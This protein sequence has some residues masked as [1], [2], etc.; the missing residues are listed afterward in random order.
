MVV[1]GYALAAILWIMLSDRLLFSV[2]KNE[3]LAA[4]LSEAKGALFVVVTSLVLFYLVYR[5]L[6]RIQLSEQRFTEAQQTL[7]QAY[8]DVLGAATGG[9][10]VLATEQEIGAWLGE[11]F[12]PMHALDRADQLSEARCIII[13]VASE[14][15]VPH[16]DS[17]MLACSEA[18]T[19]AL[20]HG[21]HAEYA[22]YATRDCLQMLVR[23]FGDGIDFRSLPRATLIQGFSTTGTLGLGFTIMLDVCDRVVLA[24]GAG[25]TTVLLEVELEAPRE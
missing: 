7:R 25:G 17:F 23:D 10:L 18:L 8:V 1:G 21:R 11:P 24:T 4:R 16:M 12:L 20:K 5:Y 9:K 2:V 15:A 6:C 19:N 14:L 13:D 22:L 3:Q